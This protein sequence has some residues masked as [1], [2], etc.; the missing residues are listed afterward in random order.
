M[1][2]W[3]NAAPVT[4]S[5]VHIEMPVCSLSHTKHIISVLAR[6]A[7]EACL[8][9]E[10]WLLACKSFLPAQLQVLLGR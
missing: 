1:R 3:P 5:Q 8:L 9:A 2:Q 4:P 6:V 7:P 10:A